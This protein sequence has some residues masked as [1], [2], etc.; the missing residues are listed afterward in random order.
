LQPL[1]MLMEDLHW[2]D[3]SSLELV[4]RLVQ[5]S[6]TARVLLVCTAR[7]E[8]QSPWGARSNLT[9]MT[10]T[11]LTRRQAREMVAALGPTLPATAMDAIVARADGVPLYLEELTKAALESETPA[12]DVAT[13]DTLHDSLMARLDRLSAVK[14]VALRAA[15][16]GREFSYGLLAASSGLDEG[17]LLHGLARLVEAEV[18]VGRGTPPEGADSFKHGRVRE[19][20]HASPRER[21]AE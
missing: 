17:A 8:F 6:P 1:I 11:R 7:P 14:E 18:L 10:L 5:Q 12:G 13:P 4:E 19:T 21:P 16:L 2:C 9:A 3:P 20:A 15:V